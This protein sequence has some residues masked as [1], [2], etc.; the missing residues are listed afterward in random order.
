MILNKLPRLK[1]NPKEKQ[2]DLWWAGG[3]A[4]SGSLEY[5]SLMLENYIDEYAKYY[6]CASW[7]P[8]KSAVLKM[9]GA[10]YLQWHFEI[11]ESND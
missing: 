3:V 4:E 1:V 9:R 8:G 11:K 2:Y 10:D 7:E 6:Y 5:V